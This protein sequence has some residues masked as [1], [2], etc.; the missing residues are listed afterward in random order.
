MR[1]PPKLRVAIL[2]FA[3]L[4]LPS[5]GVWAEDSGNARHS[6]K[7][8]GNATGKHG[9]KAPQNRAAKASGRQ[10]HE[11][12]PNKAGE[13]PKNA[14]TTTLSKTNKTTRALSNFEKKQD[15]TGEA[16]M[17]NHYCPVKTRTDSTG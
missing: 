14:T 13:V 5:S 11:R 2:T 4:V 9:A 17:Q 8:R 7:D 6:A 10:L 15:S 12:M 16:I 3:A 1:V